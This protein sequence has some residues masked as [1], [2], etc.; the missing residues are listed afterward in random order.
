[1]NRRPMSLSA[2]VFIPAFPVLFV[3]ALVSCAPKRVIKPSGPAVTLVYGGSV[4]EERRWSLEQSFRGKVVNLG[5]PQ[6]VVVKARAVIGERIESVEGNGWR[7]VRMTTDMSPLEFNGM[8]VE[9]GAVPPHAE[10]LLMRSPAGDVEPMEKAEKGGDTMA[11]VARSLGSTFPVLPPVPARPGESWRRE[12]DQAS[13]LGGTFNVVTIGVFEGMEEVDGV[14]CAR[15][16]MEGGI[17]LKDAPKGG[18]LELFRLEYKGV[19]RFVPG[20]GRL[21]DSVQDGTLRLKGKMGKSPL[22]ALLLFKSSLTPYRAAGSG[23]GAVPKK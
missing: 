2:S 6:L 18:E 12:Q 21:L 22:E 23:A 4:G 1:M 5:M 16:R 10:S 9:L 15:L 8:A 17:D 19:V 3:L 20:E 11:W 14:A 7:K 13:P